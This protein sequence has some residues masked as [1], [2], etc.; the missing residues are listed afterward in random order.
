MCV[1]CEETNEEDETICK[2]EDEACS[3]AVRFEKKCMSAIAKRKSRYVFRKASL[4]V[5]LLL[6]L[7]ILGGSK[8]YVLATRT[9]KECSL[10]GTRENS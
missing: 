1:L 9:A 8:S 5:L 6:A 2:T 3:R 7:S 4:K 10:A